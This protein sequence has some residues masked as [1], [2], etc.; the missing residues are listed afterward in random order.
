[1]RIRSLLAL[2][3][4]LAACGS[5]MDSNGDGA[6]YE[7][8]GGGY[9]GGADLGGG[10][11]VV[12]PGGGG[13]GGGPIQSGQLT[14]AEWRDLDHWPFWLDLLGREECAASEAKWGFFTTGRVPVRVTSVGEPVADVEV[15]LVGPG[16]RVEYRART[17]VHGNA[18]L[19]AGLFAAAEGPFVAEV[20][21][22]S[23]AASAPATPGGDVV[24]LELGSAPGHEAVLD[25]AFAID[26]T[27]SMWDELDY[28]QAELASVIERVRAAHA[29]PIR[30]SVNFYRD[31]GDEY[32]VRTFPFTGD[33]RLTLERLA[34]QDANGGGDW[35]EAVDLALEATVEQLEWSGSA[36][37]RLLFLLLDA[38]AHGEFDAVI[39]RLQGAAAAAAAKG[40]RLVPVMA[41]GMDPDGELLLRFLAI[42]TGGTF[43]FLTD[44][45]GIGNDHLEPR[46]G[47]VQVE[48]LD[49]LLVRVVGEALGAP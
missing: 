38:P 39:G 26:T 37:A 27:G 19:F 1:M 16:G 5:G 12:S 24:G 3:P 8:A 7:G 6:Y 10:D 28:L 17:D 46:V 32:V 40:I 25:L 18:E 31:A 11:V 21:T 4:L 34:A 33:E 2:L 20:A 30:S 29:L 43:V 14:A 9:G 22:A 35:P 36:R 44:H 48:Y 23:G 49:D 15:R 42:S 47:E 41:S 13:G 45:S